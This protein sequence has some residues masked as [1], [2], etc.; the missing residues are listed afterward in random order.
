GAADCRSDGSALGAW[1][2]TRMPEPSNSKVAITIDRPLDLLP[3][4]LRIR[5]TIDNTC[6]VVTIQSNS[7]AKPG[8]ERSEYENV[9]RR[10]DRCRVDVGVAGGRSGKGGA[11]CRR[12]LP[13]SIGRLFGVLRFCLGARRLSPAAKQPG[14]CGTDA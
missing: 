13:D 9:E 1:A 7:R 6:L 4:C 5:K 8:M 10:L 11:A 2:G 14:V 3:R 12:A